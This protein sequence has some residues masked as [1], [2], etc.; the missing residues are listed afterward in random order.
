M[1]SGSFVVASLGFSMYS[2]MSPVNNGC[3][4]ISFPSGESK[5]PCL[6]PDLRGN[7][8]S[9]SLLRTLLVVLSYMS[10][11]MLR[12]IPSMP[13]FW[14]VFIINGCWILSEPFLRLFGCF[15]K[16]WLIF[17]CDVSSLLCV[18]FLWLQQVAAALHWGAWAS[19]CSGFSCCRTWAVG[20]LAS[21]AAVHGLS[22]CS[23]WALVARRLS[24]FSACGIF[25][26][27]GLNLCTLHWQADFK[28]LNHQGSPDYM[29]FILLFVSV[30]HTD[31]FANIE[32]SLLPWGKSHLIM[33]YGF[34]WQLKQ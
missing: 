8:F 7:A 4:T 31:L 25:L 19:R 1:S 29:I 5:H 20:T 13:T 11:I 27:K 32:K 9:F 34:P 33:V 28:P 12:Y 22:H 10:F 24:C 2:I 30:Y 21:V 17:V 23:S 18:G 15:F 26:D 6:V 14:R 3:F 16:K